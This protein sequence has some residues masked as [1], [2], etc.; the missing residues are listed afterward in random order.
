MWIPGQALN[1]EIIEM[2]IAA[3]GCT[4]VKAALSKQ[5]Q[6]EID[7]DRA[8]YKGKMPNYNSLTSGDVNMQAK[9]AASGYDTYGKVVITSNNAFTNDNVY[10]SMKNKIVYGKAP[11]DGYKNRGNMI[12][13]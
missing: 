13:V 8:Q 1:R 3:L 11:E 4:E 12:I 2:F 7:I 9:K 5:I 10:K 6:S